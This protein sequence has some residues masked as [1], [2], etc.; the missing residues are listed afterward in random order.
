MNQMRIA[1]FSRYK[2]AVGIVQHY[3]QFVGRNQRPLLA[4]SDKA[5]NVRNWAQ[6]CRTARSQIAAIRFNADYDHFYE[7]SRHY[8]CQASLTT[9]KDLLANVLH[10]FQL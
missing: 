2:Q 7:T 8:F 5:L 6:S 9:T 4:C 3:C 1:T 10:S